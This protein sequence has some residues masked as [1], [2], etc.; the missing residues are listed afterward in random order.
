MDEV[1]DRENGG[2]R[3]VELKEEDEPIPDTFNLEDGDVGTNQSSLRREEFYKTQKSPLK[4]SIHNSGGIKNL[5]RNLFAPQN[6]ISRLAD[7]F[8]VEGEMTIEGTARYGSCCGGILTILCTALI[9]GS[10]FYF[11]QIYTSKNN[12]LAT[13]SYVRFGSQNNLPN[14]NAPS[15]RVAATTTITSQQTDNFN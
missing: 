12:Y 10:I 6:P 13:M 5:L 9:I 11:A 8:G 7:L 4:R 2:S 14:P 3:L 15:G 1:R